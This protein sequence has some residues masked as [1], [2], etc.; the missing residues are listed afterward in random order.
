MAL[1]RRRVT[2]TNAV[3]T[4]NGVE[5]H[6]AEDFVDITHIDAYVADAK[7]RWQAVTVGDEPDDGPAGAAGSY[8]VAAAT[9]P[10]QEG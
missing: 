5:I 3:A 9:T 2:M 8:D 7:T 6:Q 1:D 10:P 4:A